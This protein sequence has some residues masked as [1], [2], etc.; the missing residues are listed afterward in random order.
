MF[1]G[2]FL[3]E[4]AALGGDQGLSMAMSSI[5]SCLERTKATYTHTHKY[6]YTCSL[7]FASNILIMFLNL[8]IS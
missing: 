2:M 7:I 6:L 1:Q 3:A 5:N 8:A 4:G